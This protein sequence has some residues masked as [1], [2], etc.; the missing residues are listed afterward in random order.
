MRAGGMRVL[1]ITQ[2]DSAHDRRFLRAIHQ[3]GVQ[4]GVVR[5]SGISPRGRLPDGVADFTPPATPGRTGMDEMLRMRRHLQSIFRAFAPSVIHAGPIQQGAFLAGLSGLHPL[6]AMSWGSDLLLGAR[7]GTGRWMARWALSRSRLLLCDCQTVR[8]A[9]IELGVAPDR[10][11]VFPWGVDLQR[12]RPGRSSLLR[13]KL[14]WGG[15]T[16]LLSARSFEPVYGV[17]LVIGAFLR[18]APTEPQL[19]LLLLGEGSL[20]AS[21]QRRI[22][23]AGLLG[24]VH[25]AGGVSEDHLPEYFRAADLYVSASHSDG[26]SVTLLEALATGVPVLVSDLPSNQEWIEEGVQGWTFEAGSSSALEQGIR[27]AL[28]ERRRSSGMGRAARE[29]VESKADWRRSSRMLI[30]AYQM[31]SGH[32]IG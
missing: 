18:L 7:K 32:G 15:A 30:D 12:F 26:T 19:R 6:I 22:E 28:M 10:V 29:L 11:V 8:Q 20:R 31:V 3:A 13:R 17:D 1:Y 5:L 9:A 23:Q 27:R 4:A 24:R 25:F 21:L 14:G 16:V 2:G